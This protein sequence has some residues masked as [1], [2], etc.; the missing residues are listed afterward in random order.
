M[1]ILLRAE[2]VPNP[3]GRYLFSQSACPSLYSKLVR[4]FSELTYLV[5]RLLGESN[6]QLDWGILQTVF[7]N[8][9]ILIS[10]HQSL[11]ETVKLNSCNFLHLY[12]IEP[13]LWDLSIKRTSIISII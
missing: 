3:W 2:I 5:M 1:G 8:L 6:G 10:R 9:N 11:L 7:K 12:S 4:A 13:L